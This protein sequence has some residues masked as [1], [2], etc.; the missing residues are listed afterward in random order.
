MVLK[1]AKMLG[2]GPRWG[3]LQRFPDPLANSR[4]RQSGN[5]MRKWDGT[6]GKKKGEGRKGR[7]KGDKKGVGLAPPP[8]KFLLAPMLPHQR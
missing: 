7:G 6:Q 1:Y 3:S 8:Q 4:G 5:G 2:P